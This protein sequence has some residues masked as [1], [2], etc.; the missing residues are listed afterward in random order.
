LGAG[1]LRG[2]RPFRFE[3]CW[4]SLSNG[5]WAPILVREFGF[6]DIALFTMSFWHGDAGFV[7]RA[8][9]MKNEE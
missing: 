7:K 1:L 5:R 9:K 4:F 3:S 6:A 2:K 8:L